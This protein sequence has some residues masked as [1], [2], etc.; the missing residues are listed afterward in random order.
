M[1]TKD[2]HIFKNDAEGNLVFVGDFEGLYKA[3]ED[4]WQQREAQDNNYREYYWFSRLNMLNVLSRIA[5]NG[6]VLEVGCGLGQVCQLILEAKIFDEVNGL[7]ISPTAIEKAKT[8][9]SGINFISGNI[10]DKSFTDN[11]HKVDLIIFNQILW[12]ILPDLNIC[13]S[14]A[15]NMLKPNGHL[16]ITHAFLKSEQKYGR[17]IVDG[18]DGLIRYISKQEINYEFIEAKL[19]LENNFEFNDGY[20]LLKKVSSNMA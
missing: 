16:L 7:D 9:Y 19:D 13:L 12:Y 18:F 6:S 8:N 11:F 5:A 15:Y 17:E 3:E 10:V 1:S 2:E 4:P 14:N 20:V